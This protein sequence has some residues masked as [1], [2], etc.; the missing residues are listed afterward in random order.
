MCTSFFYLCEIRQFD[1]DLSKVLNIVYVYIVRVSQVYLAVD[2]R[3]ASLKTDTF[4]KT[5]EEKMEDIFAQKEVIHFS[6]RNPNVSCELVRGSF[7]GVS[8]I[9][10]VVSVP[11]RWK[12]ASSR[13]GLRR[14]KHGSCLPL[15]RPLSNCSRSLSHS[16]PRNKASAKCCRLGITG[17]TLQSGVS[18]TLLQNLLCY[19]VFDV[20]VLIN[21]DVSF[22]SQVVGALFLLPLPP[23]TSFIL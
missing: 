20:N 14:C 12:K 16:S 2:E 9:A 11:C 21:L 10:G 23:F 4:S 7:W 8:Q 18:F 5:R 13:A 6:D 3:L 17:V 22:Y 15:W 19:H 1:S